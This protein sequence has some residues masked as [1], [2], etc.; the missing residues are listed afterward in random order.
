LERSPIQTRAVAALERTPP[1]DLDVQLRKKRYNKLL[2]LAD[3]S[4]EIIDF[5]DTFQAHKL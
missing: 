1:T 5:M 2:S 4:P 3:I